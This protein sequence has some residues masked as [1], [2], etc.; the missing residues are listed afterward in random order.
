MISVLFTGL[1]IK[2]LSIFFLSIILNKKSLY[3]LNQA[4]KTM[5]ESMGLTLNDDVQVALQRFMLMHDF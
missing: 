4:R 3:S 1:I 2:I 5:R